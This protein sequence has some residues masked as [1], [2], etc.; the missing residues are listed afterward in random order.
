[1]AKKI[2]WSKAPKAN[3][4][5][6]VDFYKK[7]KLKMDETTKLKKDTKKNDLGTPA[8]PAPKPKPNPRKKPTA[9]E[10]KADGTRVDKIDLKSS[11]RA[12]DNNAID[13]YK[14]ARDGMRKTRLKIQQAEYDKE[15]RNREDKDKEGMTLSQRNK[16]DADRISK[17]V[18]EA[19]EE[20]KSAVKMDYQLDRKDNQ[21]IAKMIKKLKNSN[22]GSPSKALVF[23]P[24]NLNQH[25][26]TKPTPKNSTV[27]EENKD[28]KKDGKEVKTDKEKQLTLNTI[29]EAEAE[30]AREFAALNNASPMAIKNPFK[31]KKKKLPKDSQTTGGNK[32]RLTEQQFKNALQEEADYEARA[33]NI[34]EPEDEELER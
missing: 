27:E 26:D 13:L 11:K 5:A 10:M 9:N 24:K 19:M 12:S 30:G 25:L 29:K 17:S 3:T 32:P 34:D 15:R 33:Y 21:S 8:G 6:R 7:N 1:M 28:P 4:K 16:Y 31:K 2:D 18:K 20:S 23:Q 22:C 14:D